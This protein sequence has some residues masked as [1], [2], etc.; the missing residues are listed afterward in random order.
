MG[1]SHK[2]LLYNGEVSSFNVFV[3]DTGMLLGSFDVFKIEFSV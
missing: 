3:Y 1:W 2:Y